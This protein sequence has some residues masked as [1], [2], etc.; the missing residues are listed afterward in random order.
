MEKAASLLMDEISKVIVGQ[1]QTIRLMV[2]G[3]LAGGHILIEGV[4]GIAKT[5]AA[6]MMAKALGLQFSRIQFTPDLMP[7]DLTG[8]SVFHP[9]NGKFEFHKGP[10]FT[11]LLLA[12]EINRSPA[13]TQSALFEVMEEYSITVD[14]VT[15]SIPPPFMV[16]ATQNPIEMEGT[17]NLPEAQLD[18][19]MIRLKMGY[20]EKDEEVSILQRFKEDFYG[21]GIGEVRQ[22]LEKE[23]ILGLRSQVQRIFISDEL[24][25][26]IAALVTATRQN[27]NL[28]LGA[29]PRASLGLLRMAKALAGMSGREYV[30]PEDIQ[31]VAQAV[32]CH[33]LLL[34]P[35]K[36]L[37]GITVEWVLKEII[38]SIPVPR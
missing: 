30:I 12:D 5:L 15:Y 6:R 19:F 1:R 31:D 32:I 29:S 2:A 36:E 26:Y 28:M 14:G 7:G 18:R 9:E 34:D 8:S 16:L 38:Q 3:M 22:C 24:V 11:N 4:P 17:Y 20:P 37:A 10:V 21:T 27:K 25:G 13:K 33:R 23:E 35:E